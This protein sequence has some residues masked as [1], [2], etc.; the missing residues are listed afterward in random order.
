MS[1]VAAKIFVVYRANE[2]Y[3]LLGLLADAVKTMLNA[4]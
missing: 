3:L 4:Y 1:Y 2:H